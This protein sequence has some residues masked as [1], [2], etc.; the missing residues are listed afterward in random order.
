[1]AGLTLRVA[2]VNALF[3]IQAL[4]WFFSS[5]PRTSVLVD[6]QIDGGAKEKGPRLFDGMHGLA[7]KEAQETFLSQVRGSLAIT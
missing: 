1:M 2:I 4:K 7:L 3:L 6:A 5:Y